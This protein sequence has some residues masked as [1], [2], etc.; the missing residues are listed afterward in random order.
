MDDGVDVGEEHLH[1][2]RRRDVRRGT[3]GQ[4]RVFGSMGA[5]MGM[6]MGSSFFT[7]GGGFG[8]VGGEEDDGEVQCQQM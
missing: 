1:R 7:G 5:G 4:S 3:E 8:G 6:G 2:G